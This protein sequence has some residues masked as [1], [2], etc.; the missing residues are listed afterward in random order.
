MEKE[1]SK[2]HDINPLTDLCRGR[3][4]NAKGDDCPE[5]RL[6]RL[7]DQQLAITIQMRTKALTSKQDQNNL[8]R[9]GPRPRD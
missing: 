9:K 4:M 6:T 3:E 2:L 8:I 7:F 5:K 1:L